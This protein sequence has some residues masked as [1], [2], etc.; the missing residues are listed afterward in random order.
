MMIRAEKNYVLRDL[1]E[2]FARA[3]RKDDREHSAMKQIVRQIDAIDS[4]L[5]DQITL[6][7]EKLVM[8]LRRFLRTFDV[9]VTQTL[10]L[11]V[12]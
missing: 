12:V 1:S 2:S 8:K 3:S 5:H 11:F 6:S 10:R 9:N 4:H 7:F